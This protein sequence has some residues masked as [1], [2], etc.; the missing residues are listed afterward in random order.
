M[1][2]VQTAEP[3]H[4]SSHIWNL[5]FSFRYCILRKKSVNELWRRTWNSHEGG[6]GNVYP[7]IGFR[8]WGQ[9]EERGEIII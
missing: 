9:E 1:C 2:D 6:A 3:T 7:G 4:R 8:R 5:V